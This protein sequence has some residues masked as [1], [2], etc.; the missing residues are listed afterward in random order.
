MGLKKTWYRFRISQK[1]TWKLRSASCRIPAGK[2]RFS[3]GSLPKS[4]TPSSSEK[5][6]SVRTT[7]DHGNLRVPHQCHPPLEI[8]AKKSLVSWRKWQRGVGQW[9]PKISHGKKH[10]A[11]FQ[12]S[13]STVSLAMAAASGFLNW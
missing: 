8:I 2:S 3:W 5:K 13:R 12:P 11:T 4:V 6:T 7:K 9:A 1:I 10:G